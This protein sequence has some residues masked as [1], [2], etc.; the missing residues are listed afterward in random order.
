[1]HEVTTPQGQNLSHGQRARRDCRRH[2]FQPYPLID[3]RPPRSLV[4][5]GAAALASAR[6]VKQGEKPGAMSPEDRVQT[7][8][9]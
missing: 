2:G 7:T 5:R 6:A 8:S 3:R 1:M 4:V 9:P